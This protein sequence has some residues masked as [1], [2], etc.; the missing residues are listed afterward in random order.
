MA[1]TE[2]K[3]FAFSGKQKGSAREETT[4]VSGTKDMNVQ[5]RQQTPLHPLRHQHQEVEVRREKRILRGRNQSGKF[6]RQPCKN[7]L[8]KLP[9]DY[10]HP[11]E[12]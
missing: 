4:A 1:L 3:E 11:P 2:E 10:L 8:T 7:F 12:C 9:C 5:N 6:N